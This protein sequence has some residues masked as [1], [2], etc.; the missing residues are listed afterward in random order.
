MSNE[1]LRLCPHTNG[2]PDFC[3]PNILLH[4]RSISQETGV[5]ASN[6]FIWKTGSQ[7]RWQTNILENH[8]TQV[9]I[10]ACTFYYTDWEGGV[11]GYFKF[12]GVGIL[13]S[14]AVDVGQMTMFSMKPPTDKCYSLFISLS[15]NE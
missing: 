8:L 7:R 2:F 6:D 11:T 9:R 3:V 5:R 14:A 12:L 1:Q 13:C 15:L 10:K 4:N